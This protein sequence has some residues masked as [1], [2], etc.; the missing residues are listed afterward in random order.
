MFWRKKHLHGL[1]AIARHFRVNSMDLWTWHRS[2][3][4]PPPMWRE[5]AVWICN[6]KAMQTWLKN[7]NLLPKTASI[8]DLIKNKKEQKNEKRRV[9]N[10][11]NWQR[12]IQKQ[13]GRDW[14]ITDDHLRRKRLW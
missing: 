8:F 3:A 6:T 13:H 4:D 14:Q 10:S 7:N 9:K 12:K 2:R 1:D 5:N 11:E